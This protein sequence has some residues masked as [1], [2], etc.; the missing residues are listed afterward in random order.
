[1]SE[2]ALWSWLRPYLPLGHYTRVE[3]GEAGPG[4]PDVHY[5]IRPRVCGTIELKDAQ[6]PNRHPPFKGVDDG[7]HHSQLQW[8][9]QNVAR[10]GVVWIVARVGKQVFWVHGRMADHF[11]GCADLSTIAT[12]VLPRR[13]REE[14]LSIMA[15]LLE[16][17]DEQ[18]LRL[19]GSPANQPVHR[20]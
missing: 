19:Y 10:G 4:F 12:F 7:L 14:H 16:G 11:N 8:M 18:V 13:V 20:V 1:M 6:H 5:Q 15:K 9:R 2:T 17:N 3:N